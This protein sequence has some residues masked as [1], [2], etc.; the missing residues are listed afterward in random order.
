MGCASGM[1][2]VAQHS[3]APSSTLWGGMLLLPKFVILEVF[4]SIPGTDCYIH[5]PAGPWQW[6]PLCENAHIAVENGLRV[7]EEFSGV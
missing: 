5:C 4:L 6:E 7:G 3:Y 1:S 2:Q